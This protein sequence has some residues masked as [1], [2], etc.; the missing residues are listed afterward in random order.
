MSHSTGSADCP[1]PTRRIV[2]SICCGRNCIGR[3][4]A[5]YGRFCHVSA[6][7]SGG[8][9]PPGAIP[10]GSAPRAV[11]GM[12]PHCQLCSASDR[13]RPASPS[14]SSRYAWP[15]GLAPGRDIAISAETFRNEG[16]LVWTPGSL[17]SA[18]VIHAGRKC[19]SVLTPAMKLDAGSEPSGGRVKALCSR[20]KRPVKLMVPR[21]PRS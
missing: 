9:K 13:N 1:W 15:A 8:A 3:P 12:L 10:N 19:S 14:N 7:A 11:V 17:S 6:A 16:A 4:E 2:G 5:S 20:W 18:R 21:A